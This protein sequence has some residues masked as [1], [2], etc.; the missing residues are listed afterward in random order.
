MDTSRILTQ[1]AANLRMSK[2]GRMRFKEMDLEIN[3]TELSCKKN[4]RR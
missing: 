4:D 2:D 1:C 3:S